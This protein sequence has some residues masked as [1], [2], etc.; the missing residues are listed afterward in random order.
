V[1]FQYAVLFT[2]DS[3]DLALLSIE[4]CEHR[5]EQ[6]LQWNHPPTLQPMESHDRVFR[7]YAVAAPEKVEAELQYLATA[8]VRCEKA[9][10]AR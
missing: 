5:G 9:A 1:R 6:H 8:L 3:D 4:P 10:E 7:Q 2:E